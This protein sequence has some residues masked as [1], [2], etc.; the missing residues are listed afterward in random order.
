VSPLPLDALGQRGAGDVL[1]ALHDLDEPLLATRLHRR[2]PDAA[3]AEERGGHA[4]PARRREVRV[5]P[6]LAVEVPVHVDEAGRGEQAVGVEGATRR[7]I[8]PADVHDDALANGDVGSTRAL[9]VPSTTVP[10]RITRSCAGYS[11]AA[12]RDAGRA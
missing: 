2:E 7:A 8:D 3:V 4:V 12:F 11:P 5:P 1:D 10:P 9:P 6:R